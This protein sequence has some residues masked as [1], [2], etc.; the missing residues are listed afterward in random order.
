MGLVLS[1]RGAPNST[2]S[3]ITDVYL[4]GGFILSCFVRRDST[5]ARRHYTQ[6]YGIDGAFLGTANL[7]PDAVD[8]SGNIY[9]L[10][11]DSLIILRIKG[12]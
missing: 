6:F 10:E 7:S 9:L 2:K 11:K 8:D 5:R 4:G 3:L 12:Q 1:F